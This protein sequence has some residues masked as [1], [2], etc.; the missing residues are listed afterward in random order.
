METIVVGVDGSECSLA[1]LRWAI[2]EARLRAARVVAVNA[3]S[4]PHVSTASEARRLIDVDFEPLRADALELLDT[5]I[6]ETLAGANGV[7]VEPVVVEGP[8]A[9]ALIAAAEGASLLVVG[10]RG[11]GSLRGLLL[12]S[13]SQ[14]CAH[15]SPCPTVVVRGGER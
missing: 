13:V 2:G 11:R 3:W 7:V 15:R 1:A 4:V 5:A 14:E 8:A 6:D 9:E 10:C 12:G